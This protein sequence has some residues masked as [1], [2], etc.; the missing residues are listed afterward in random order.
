MNVEIIAIADEVLKGMV[1]NTNSTNISASLAKIGLRVSR[2]T[3]L[4]DEYEDLKKGIQEALS[5][6]D[7]V[8]TTG[9]LGPTLD[10]ITRAVAADIFSSEFTLNQDV[11]Q[12]LIDRFGTALTSLQD[13]ATVPT[14]AK[15]LRNKVGTAPGFFF[16]D[17]GKCLILMPGV[18]VEMTPMLENEAIPLLKEKIFDKDRL[19]VEKVF[20][21]LLSENKLDPSLRELNQ[22]FNG[23][24]IGIYP[25]YGVLTVVLRGVD[26]SIL[27]KAKQ[28]LINTFPSNV[29]ESRSGKIE[30]ALF[31]LLIE[32]GSTLSF[33]ESCTGGL[34]AHKMT[35]LP[36][37]SDFFLGSLVTYSNELKKDV[38]HVPPEVIDSFGAVSADTV[39]E[40]LKGLFAVTHSD[41]GIAVSGIAGP[42]GGSI[43]KPVGTIWAAIGRRGHDP[44]VFSMHL[45]G[46]RETIILMTVNR[47]IALL[48][49]KIKFGCPASDI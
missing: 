20:F 3:V 5:R 42:S 36:G 9:G 15:I 43:E 11:Y 47:L 18:P 29:Y 41:Y 28:D 37:A 30:E 7:I 33:A 25:G 19:F 10:D 48:Y 8:I 2:H 45:K 40:M 4:P 13:Q 16:E 39:K 6:C 38:L 17:K 34:L 26:P 49:R 31:D 22:K 23:I 46:V 1:V 27:S 12:D 14:K 44:D 21:S 35:L 32:E 24:D